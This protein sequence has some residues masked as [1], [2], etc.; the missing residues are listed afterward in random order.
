MNV[1][2]FSIYKKNVY[3]LVLYFK[4]VLFHIQTH[5]IWPSAC[6]YGYHGLFDFISGS[7]QENS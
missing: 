5:D 4:L 3:L 7:F 1:I 2:K 6:F